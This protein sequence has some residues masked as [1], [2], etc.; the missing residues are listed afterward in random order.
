MKTFKV[1]LSAGLLAALV[2]G[3]AGRSQSQNIPELIATTDEGVILYM[4]HAGREMT[5]A[6]AECGLRV[7]YHWNEATRFMR[8]GMLASAP[9]FEPGMEVFVYYSKI[10]GR[11][12]L[13]EVV[14]K[15][16]P[17]FVAAPS[18]TCAE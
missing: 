11:P 13:R 18:L 12:T 8:H 17:M 5:L 16:D 10:A 3:F 2:I 15:K 1:M 7:V 14:W 4:D 6:S 9:E